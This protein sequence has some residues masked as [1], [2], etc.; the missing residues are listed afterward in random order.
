MRVR[1]QNCEA[2]VVAESARAAPYYP[3]CSDRCRMADL[4]RWFT[5]DYRVSRDFLGSDDT[6]E[7]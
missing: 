1:C 4:D 2:E 5:E 6:E 3:F 7:V